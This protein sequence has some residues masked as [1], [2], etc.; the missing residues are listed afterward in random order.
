MYSVSWRISFF[1]NTFLHFVNLREVNAFLLNCCNNSLFLQ[2]TLP[3]YCNVQ[4]QAEKQ[5]TIRQ[6]TSCQ[7]AERKNSANAF[8]VVRLL[9]FDSKKKRR[10]KLLW[11]CNKIMKVVDV[12]EQVYKS[13]VCFPSTPQTALKTNFNC[14]KMLISKSCLYLP[15]K[16]SLLLQFFLNFTVNFAIQSNL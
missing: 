5:S 15:M 11:L 8:V 2:M 12:S 16:N 3:N 10:D 7:N 13:F 6:A 14:R 1:S 9:F 4:L